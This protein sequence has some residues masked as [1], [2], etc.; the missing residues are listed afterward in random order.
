MLRSSNAE[1]HPVVTVAWVPQKLAR[2]YQHQQ[3]L[4]LSHP[5]FICDRAKSQ[6]GSNPPQGKDQ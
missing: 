5:Q 2:P 3:E 1:S 6:K 4:F